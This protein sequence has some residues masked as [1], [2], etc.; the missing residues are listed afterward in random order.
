MLIATM[1]TVGRSAFRRACRNITRR[2]RS[3][4]RRAARTKGRSSAS[5]M[6]A[7]TMRVIWARSPRTSVSTGRTRAGAILAKPARG[8]TMLDGGSTGHQYAS[9]RISTVPHTNSGSETATSVTRLVA[10]SAK[11]ARRA[12]ERTPRAMESGTATAMARAASSADWRSRS[13]TKGP[14]RHLV[15]QRGAPVP[16][17]CSA[18]PVDVAQWRRPRETELLAEGRQVLRRGRGPQDHR[19]DVAGQDLD[20]TEDHDRH[21]GQHQAQEQD[22]ARQEADQAHAGVPGGCSRPGKGRRPLA[23]SRD[24]PAV[25]R[26]GPSAGSAWSRYVQRKSQ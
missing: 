6:L 18:H 15:E 9:T 1:P 5:I 20:D 16:A 13:R 4:R 12:A 11:R 22:P 17:E 2:G 3:P 8:S 10:W 25:R 21:H 24:G 7:R 26:A 14:D 23:S 19:G